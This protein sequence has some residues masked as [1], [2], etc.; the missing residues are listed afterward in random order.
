MKGRTA[1]NLPFVLFV[2]FS[3]LMAF[4]SGPD[5]KVVQLFTQYANRAEY[6]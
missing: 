1:P 5:P 3:T 6:S 4:H 2:H